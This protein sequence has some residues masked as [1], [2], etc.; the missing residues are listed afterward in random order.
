MAETESADL[1]LLVQL[2]QSIPSGEAA[3][4]ALRRLEPFIRQAARRVSRYLRVPLQ[5]Q[6]DL[7]ACAPSLVWEKIQSFDESRGDFPGWLWKILENRQRDERKRVGRIANRTPGSSAG[8]F[9]DPLAIM[10]AKLTIDPVAR[11]DRQAEFGTHDIEVIE[12]WPVRDRLR[13]LAAAQLWDKL[14]TAT[15]EEWVRSE[16][17]PPP[18]PPSDEHV[19]ETMADW[20]KILADAMGETWEAFKQH[21]YRKRSWLANLSYVR[22]VNHGD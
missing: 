17:I 5:L 4:D 22:E 13:M 16:G 2:V 8:E 1:V 18:F 9:P 6:D 10:E 3:N 20:M 15:W 7:I 11:L 19:P 21:W 12:A 14:P